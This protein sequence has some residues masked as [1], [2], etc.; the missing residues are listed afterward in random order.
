MKLIPLNSIPTLKRSFNMNKNF[1][2]LNGGD[3]FSILQKVKQLFRVYQCR[4]AFLKLAS[5]VIGQIKVFKIL[6]AKA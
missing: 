5:S 2:I 6:F 1:F 4:D 3:L